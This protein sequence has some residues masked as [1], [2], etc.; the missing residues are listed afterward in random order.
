VKRAAHCLVLSAALLAGSAQADQLARVEVTLAGRPDWESAAAKVR[1]IGRI[2][3]GSPWRFV[4]DLRPDLE[5]ARALRALRARGASSVRSIEPEFPRDFF[6]T[7]DLDGIEGLV[8]RYKELWAQHVAAG[9]KAEEELPGLD[10]LETYLQRLRIRAYPGKTIDYSG[11]SDVVRN[12][13]GTMN[14]LPTAQ[15]PWQFMGPTNLN[16]PYRTYYGQRPINGRVNAVAYHPTVAGTYY[17][18]GAQGGVWKTTDFGATW[19]PLTDRWPTIHVSAIE[20]HP[21]SPE[22]VYVGTGDFPG[23][24]GYALGIMKSTDG[25]ANWTQYGLSTFGNAPVGDILIHP[26]TPQTL[27]AATGRG[28][29]SGR[30]YRSLDGGQTWAPVITTTGAWTGLSASAPSGGS[31]TLWA[32]ADLS[33]GASIVRRSTDNGATWTTVTVAGIGSST[34]DV[35][36]STVNPNTVYILDGGA[37]RIWKSVDNGATWTNTTSNF[38]TGYNWSQAWYDWHIGTSSLNGNDVVYTGLI[39]VVVSFNGGSTWRNMGGSNWT[40]CYSGSAITHNDQHSWAVNPNNPNEVLVGNDGGV[41]R[42]TYNPGNDT[43]TW[44]LLS[45]TLGI[46]QFYTLAVHPTNPDY[47]M[48]GTQDNATPHSFGDLAN[49]GNPGAGDGA[50]C[51]INPVNPANQYHSWQN[52]NIERTENSFGSKTNITPSWSGHSVPFIG[53]FW[54]DPNDPNLLY[55]NTN[56]LNRY[57]RTT[58]SWSLALGGQ[59][60]GATVWSCGI[61]QGDSNTIYVGTGNGGVWVSRNQGGS[62]TR[63]DRQ[64]LSGGLPNRSVVGLT[65]SPTNKNDVLVVLSGTGTGKV[66]RCMDTTAAAPTWTNVGQTGASGLPDVPGNC[67]ARDPFDPENA[68]WVGTDVGVWVTRNAGQSWQEATGTLGLPNVEVAA[69]VAN[70]TTRYLTAATFGRGI[71]RLPLTPSQRVVPSTVRLLLG[72]IE[73]GDAASLGRLDG[74]PLRVCRFIVPNATTPPV[75]FEIEGSTSFGA[76]TTLN[77]TC[78]ARATATGTFEHRMELFDWTS[79]AYRDVRTDSLGTAYGTFALSGTGAVGQYRGTG[80]L[81]RAKVSVYT[82]GPAASLNWCVETDEAFWTAGG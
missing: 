65:I 62:W 79:N 58:N 59:A 38:P 78:V 12:R 46:T 15:A 37:Q 48:G 71:W 23:S 55:T 49:W 20:I 13:L 22:T 33:S 32:V 50:G 8:A 70:G 64:G 11:Y 14:E 53:T 80:G 9:G 28:S 5:T 63:I 36:C 77:L 27:L 51:A 52:Q 72:R 25:G 40:A 18:G 45:R 68:W 6:V 24:S 31:R 30:V 35:A 56:Y 41:Y 10:Y 26:D 76:L 67:I 42:A 1:G 2:A 17:L 16:I 73:A 75:Q 47:V 19:T 66:W 4:V 43:V 60:F 3:T 29:A 34:L 74:A 54:L 21:S 82:T 61:A 69:M 57:N 39:D 44:A 81:L 7:R